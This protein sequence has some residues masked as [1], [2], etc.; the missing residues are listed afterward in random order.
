MFLKCVNSSLKI[1][2]F[3]PGKCLRKMQGTGSSAGLGLAHPLAPFQILPDTVNRNNALPGVLHRC[4][5]VIQPVPAPGP[6][7]SSPA[8]PRRCWPCSPLL[9]PRQ[10]AA[11]PPLSLQPDQTLP[12]YLNIHKAPAQ[13]PEAG[14]P[15]DLHAFA[16]LLY[17]L[18]KPTLKF[19]FLKICFELVCSLQYF[20]NCDQNKPCH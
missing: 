7:F 3:E 5:R 15:H 6:C 20:C 1:F 14:K 13:T 11:P 2:I 4:F 9:F 18:L 17:S 12:S 10:G 8:Q 16:T 19:A